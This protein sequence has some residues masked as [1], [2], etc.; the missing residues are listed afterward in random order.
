MSEAIYIRDDDSGELWG[1]TAQ[2]IRCE[3]S[4][5]VARHGAGYSRFDHL[6]DGIGLNLVQFVPLDD[7]LKVSVLTIENRAGHSRRLSVTAYVEWALGTSRGDSGPRIVTALE[8]ETGALLVRNPWN[9]EFGGRVAF[10]DLGGRQTAWTADRTEFLGRNG[11]P[12]RPAGLERHCG[13]GIRSDRP[14]TPSAAR[15]DP[16]RRPGR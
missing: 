1:P 8:S 14:S 10:L 11:G 15:R 9:A 3:E 7:A 5:Y 4:T 13:Q 16:G 6:H 12:D 2:P